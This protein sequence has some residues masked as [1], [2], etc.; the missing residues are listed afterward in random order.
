M[1]E[2][3]SAAVSTSDAASASAAP[4]SGV[5]LLDLFSLSVQS[6]PGATAGRQVDASGQRSITFAAAERAVQRLC[7]QFGDLGL[8]EGVVAIALPGVVETPV[9]LLAA[10][11][12]GLTPCLVP[13]DLDP[14]HYDALAERLPL[15]AVVTVAAHGSLRP[16]ERWRTAA[17]GWPRTTP[18]MGFGERLPAGVLPVSPVLG[19]APDAGFTAPRAGR[20]DQPPV[21]TVRAGTEGLDIYRHE[22][23]GLVAAGLWLVLRAG[24]NP[25]ESILTTIA[26]TSL[27]GLAT[28]FVPALLT[29]GTLWQVPQFSSRAFL[30][31]LDGMGGGHVV[32]PGSL[33]RMMRDAGLMKDRSVVLLHRPPVRLDMP[34]AVSGERIVDVLSCA[35]HAVLMAVRDAEGRVALALGEDMIP[36][37]RGGVV[38]RV[39]T[40]PG[41]QLY[42]AGPA[43]ATRLATLDRPAGAAASGFACRTDQRRR[44]V[45]VS[46]A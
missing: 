20:R 14:V 35:D 28:G 9:A 29:G 11:R 46:A 36:D 18:V 38:S 39:E 7:E 16:A 15:A 32:V 2:A 37:Q 8:S 31:A 43:V 40:G 25:S 23:E 17:S 33:E 45:A 19:S 22:Q 13:V 34:I 5:T 24:I 42:F 10:L 6:Q 27:A 4:W 41:G 12:A 3:Q 21:L 44:I 30:D 1:T 26:P